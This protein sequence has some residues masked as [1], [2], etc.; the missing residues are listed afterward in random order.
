MSLF[1][2]GTGA[3]TVIFL[4]CGL[5]EARPL[6]VRD[7]SP[8]AE[9]IVDGRDAQYASAALRLLTLKRAVPRQGR[10]KTAN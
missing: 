2:I 6:N 4:A 5:A 9:A 7:S 8:A 3:L 10:Q 1:S